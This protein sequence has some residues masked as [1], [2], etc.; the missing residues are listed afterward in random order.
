MLLSVN[1]FVCAINTFSVTF[2][3]PS[4]LLHAPSR[5][6]MRA[7]SPPTRCAPQ[8]A[9]IKQLLNFTHATHL[10]RCLITTNF[11]VYGLQHKAAGSKESDDV[12]GQGTAGAASPS[13][14]Q[15]GIYS[16]DG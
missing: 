7:W 11:S 15:V 1:K 10:I 3:A 2:I 16:G 13:V 4:K 9:A 6:D 8:R 14:I 5:R 12:K